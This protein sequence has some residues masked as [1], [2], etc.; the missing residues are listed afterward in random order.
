MSRD[1]G[2]LGVLSIKQVRWS[3]LDWHILLFGLSLLALGVV[4]VFGMSN[5]AGGD[6]GSATLFDAHIQKVLLTLPLIGLALLVRPVWLRRN[7]MLIY[8]GCL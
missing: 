4:F 5:P 8:G 6:L 1:S 3:D 7:A 2:F